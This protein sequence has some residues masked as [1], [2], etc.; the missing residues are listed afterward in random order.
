MLRIDLARKALTIATF[1]LTTGLFGPYELVQAQ[2]PSFDFSGIWTGR[3]Y[4]CNGGPQPPQYVVIKIEDGAVIAT[5]LT[6]DPCIEA[7]EVTWLGDYTGN[8]F[9]ARMSRRR[10]GRTYP[11]LGCSASR[12]RRAADDG[13]VRGWARPA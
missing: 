8:P 7:G 6:G 1:L 9:S 2:P 10:R 13:R 5:K 11:R 12:R 3:G 4:W